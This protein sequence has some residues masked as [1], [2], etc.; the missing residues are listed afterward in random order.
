MKKAIVIGASP[1]PERYSFMAVSR[2]HKAGY[3]VYAI[4]KRKGMIG[5]IAISQEWPKEEAIDLLSIYLNET[6]QKEYEDRILHLNAHKIVFN[7]GAENKNLEQSLLEK[8]IDAEN[9]CTLVMLSTG[10]L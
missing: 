8:G 4:G 1:N 3:Q 2:L 6:N 10:I 5:D 9:A 7:P